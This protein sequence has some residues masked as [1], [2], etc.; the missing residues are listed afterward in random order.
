MNNKQQTTNNTLQTKK[1]KQH[2]PNNTHEQQTYN[3]QKCTQQTPN[4]TQ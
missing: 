4:K 3:Q 1:N 2:R